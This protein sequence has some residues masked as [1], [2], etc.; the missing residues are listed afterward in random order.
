MIDALNMEFREINI[1]DKNCKLCG[2]D[3][4]VKELIDYE[5]FCGIKGDLNM[6]LGK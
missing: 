3:P 1:R 2:D 4:D 5:I 6:G